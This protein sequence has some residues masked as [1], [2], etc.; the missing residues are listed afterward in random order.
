MVILLL[1]VDEDYFIT[2]KSLAND[3]WDNA[4]DISDHC[5]SSTGMYGIRSS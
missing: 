1:L 2:S 5:F 4:K 3:H